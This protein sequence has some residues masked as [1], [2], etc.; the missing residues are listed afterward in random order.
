[1]DNKMIKVDVN[2]DKPDE[3]IN[4]AQTLKKVIV[5][6]K[7]Y[8]NIQGK[9]YPLVEAWQFCGAVLK[10]LPIIE[11]LKDISV[12]GEVKYRAKVSLKK[13]DTGDIIGCGIAICSGKEKGKEYFQ[14]YAIA[15]MAQTRA[16]G[17]A[18]RN[19]FG[20]LM[21]LAGYEA[22]PSEEMD[23]MKNKTENTK[24]QIMEVY[25]NERNNT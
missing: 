9:N 1:M 20:W 11:S 6:Q 13:I 16:V 2:I 5:E 12:D 8:A 19:S 4:F 22:T 23:F 3:M 24:E 18:Y 15:S 21:K 7:M 14:E 17:K 10:C 25:K